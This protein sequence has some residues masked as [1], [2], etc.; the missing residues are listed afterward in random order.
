LK[1]IEPDSKYN[2][3]QFNLLN[4]YRNLLAGNNKKVYSTILEEF[5]MVPFDMKSNKSAMVVALQFVNR[6]ADVQ[7]IFEAIKM[8]SMD[9]QNCQDCIIR[10]YVKS[11]ADIELN[12]YDGVI[13]LLEPIIETVEDLF[14]KKAL[15]ASYVR[16]GNDIKAA[17]FLNKL[18]LLN[19]LEIYED[20]CLFTAKEYLLLGNTSKANSYLTKI[21]TVSANATNKTLFA[22]ALYFKNDYATAEKILKELLAKNP[23]NIDFIA[24]LAICNFKMNNQKQAEKYTRKHTQTKK[25]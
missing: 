6:P 18:E 11:L 19:K 2:K 5:A 4:S 8:D 20:L 24:K 16:S 1:I 21:T 23:E 25:I 9:I 17:K 12:K 13:K 3:R 7:P 14:L 10:I 22:E 15:I